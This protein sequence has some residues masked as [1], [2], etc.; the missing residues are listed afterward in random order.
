MLGALAGAPLLAG[1]LVAAAGP[2]AAV[3]AR[4]LEDLVL[5]RSTWTSTPPTGP[6][7]AEPLVAFL[8][9]HHTVHANDHGP[10]DVPGLLEGMRA[11]HTASRGWPDIAYHFVVDRF[12]R[13]W[14]A[15]AGSRDAGPGTA[16]AG[17]AT[18][19]NQG[20]DQKCAF[21]G[22]HRTEPPTEAAQAAMADLLALLAQRHGIDPTPG[23]TATFTSRGSNRHPSGAVV[24]TPTITGHRTMSQTAC[25]GDAGMRVV[26]DLLPAAATAR[27]A[28]PPAADPPPPAV[29]TTATTAA[30][31][32]VPTTAPATGAAAPGTEDAAPGALVGGDEDRL[33]P[34]AGAGLAAVAVGGLLA[35][36]ARRLR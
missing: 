27:I 26:T 16:V 12:G 31:T 36:R 19:G 4:R 33:L 5:P 14:E 15:R 11:F 22:D 25:P 24:T 29:A 8:L 7:P 32:T 23:A 30:P 34:A 18:G 13:V 20:S 17:D 21:L 9:V 1:P 2:A 3:P 28:G 35:L 6:I 10:D